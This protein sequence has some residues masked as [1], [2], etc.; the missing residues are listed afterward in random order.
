MSF[1]R[2]SVYVVRSSHTVSVSVLVDIIFFIWSQDLHLLVIATATCKAAKD[3]F[4]AFL[5]K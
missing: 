3:Q 2:D 4:R 5:W 1:W